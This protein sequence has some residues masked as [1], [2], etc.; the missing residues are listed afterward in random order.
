MAAGDLTLTLLITA[1]DTASGVIFNIG[2]SLEQLA[3]GNVLGAITSAATA[4]TAAVAG[5]TA[6]AVN[7]A[8][9]FDQLATTLVTSAGESRQNLEGVKSG[10]L[11]ISAATGTSTDALA[12]AMYQIE[13]SGQHG[14]DGL[15]VLKVAA[16]GAKAENADLTVVAKALTTVLTDYHMPAEKATSAMN[17]LIMAVSRG[18]TTLAELSASMGEVLPTAAALHISFPQV[19]GALAVM[20]NAGMSS[21]QAAQNLAHVLLALEAP[22][23]VATKAMQSVGLSAKQVKE[24]LANQGLPEALQLIEEHVA[25]KFPKG[26]VEYETAMK[27]IMGGLMGFKVSAMLTGDSLGILK[28]DISDIAGAMGDAS[29]DVA[30]FSDVQNTLNFQLARVNTTFQALLI[31]I[32]EKLTPILLPLVKAFADFL[33]GLLHVI[34]GIDLFGTA[35]QKM[36]QA[37]SGATKMVTGFDEE[38]NKI[39]KSLA[40][41]GISVQGATQQIQKFGEIIS[42]TMSSDTVQNDIN[43]MTKA[44][45]SLQKE[46]SQDL[47]SIGD[48]MRTLGLTFEKAFSELIAPSVRLFTQIMQ[49]AKEV[50]HVVT[51]AIN[52]E[53]F[54][55]LR[56]MIMGFADAV[57][58]IMDFIQRSGIIVQI[59][60][61][62][63]MTIRLASEAFK[64]LKKE[65]SG[66]IGPAFIELQQPI[67]NLMT[68]FVTL[69]MAISQD[70]ISILKGLIETLVKVGQAFSSGAAPAIKIFTQVL[71]GVQQVLDVFTIE[72]TGNLFPA[73]QQLGQ[74]VGKATAKFLDFLQKSGI[75]QGFFDA[76]SDAV[77]FLVETLSML[78]SELSKGVGPAF[79]ILQKALQSL[80][81]ELAPVWKEI[82]EKLMPAVYELLFVIAKLVVSLLGA[83]D[84]TQ[85]WNKSAKNTGEV[86]AKAVDAIALFV[87]GVA[88]ILY[89]IDQ[90]IE[91]FNKLGTVPDWLKQWITY[92]IN[93]FQA[94]FD[95]LVGH[96][97]VPDMISKIIENFN[98]LTDIKNIV[99]T[100]M[101][102]ISQ[103]IGQAGQSISQVVQDLVSKIVDFFSQLP[104]KLAKVGENM[105]KALADAIKSGASAVTSALQSVI[106]SIT[107]GLGMIHIPGFA[108]GVTNFAGGWAVVGEQGPELLFLP[109]GSSVIPSGNSMPS[110]ANQSREDQH[111][112]IYNVL[113]GKVISK[114]VTTYQQRELR[115]QGVVRGV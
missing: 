24:A 35:T 53:M 11:D 54:P 64:D 30:G 52:T 56:S 89:L 83:A 105:M 19:A 46:V 28:K 32:G 115:V 111:M 68:A 74:E 80:A 50:I 16:Q 41:T 76:V 86:L 62:I 45:E 20:T 9:N 107:S 99:D 37:I 93:P 85:N 60:G 58:N 69:G 49:S 65:L 10:I 90:V 39:Q 8:G 23:N 13:S 48:H 14:A 29:G 88:K 7:A 17:G 78:I 110:I 36:G 18:K 34:K 79:S 102:A 59:A 40:D 106:S 73:L 104:D 77:Q 47:A 97:I 2:R 3:S 44:F 101:K 84:K 96:S 112:I 31:T 67:R 91:A 98:K 51:N 38:N 71:D 108:G 70:F 33:E 25:N 63:T 100:A 57:S 61:T 95:I 66:G 109:S 92:V 43:Y 26:S 6:A 81:T 15:S 87:D 72:I 27:Q 113:D 42:K 4:A 55:A 114:V 94:L 1:K 5:I 12:K 103:A 75:I 82:K 22:S 21:R